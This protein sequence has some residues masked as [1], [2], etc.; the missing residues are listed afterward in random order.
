MSLS[1][2]SLQRATG[3]ERLVLPSP[4]GS[5]ICATLA[6]RGATVVAGCLRNAEAVAAHL[7]DALAGGATVAVVP[8]GERWPDGSLRPAVEDLWGAGAVL[9][10]LDPALMSPE[11]ELATL[12]YERFRTR[13]L[14]HLLSCA[15]GRELVEK[16]FE[17]DVVI[18]GRV[19]TTRRGAPA[20]GGRV[21]ARVPR[22]ELGCMTPRDAARK[23]TARSV[24]GRPSLRDV[25]HARVSTC[26]W[27]MATR[28]AS[29]AGR[30]DLVT[31]VAGLGG[32][33]SASVS[34]R[35]GGLASARGP[36]ERGRYQMAVG[37]TRD[38]TT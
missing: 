24:S 4:N 29:T 2:Q 28:L 34:R 6:G 18:A 22:A 37:P 19:N 15:S 32:P 7:A 36:A 1:P 5:T 31:G 21:R 16:G 3:I 38:L 9:A 26:R 27:V 23:T 10:G 8:A 17:P 13:P 25:G 12:A 11:A 30:A 20:G 33:G 14:E 35:V